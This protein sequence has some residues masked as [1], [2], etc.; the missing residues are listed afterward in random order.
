MILKKIMTKEI[1]TVEAD[2]TLWMVKGIFDNQSFHHL[3]VLE[4]GKI[5]G[6]V[7][8]RDLFKA[9]SPNLGTNVET[10]KDLATLNKKV[11]HI[12][13]RNPVVLSE[14]ASIFEAIELFNNQT[15]S[16]VPVVDAEQRPVGIVSWRDIMR[17]I[18]ERKAGREQNKGA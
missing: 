18:G 17:A 10:L 3:L 5:F 8:D 7:S 13:S 9:I 14:D 6:I 15:V 16:C 2:D 4:H 1:V 12:M 11:H